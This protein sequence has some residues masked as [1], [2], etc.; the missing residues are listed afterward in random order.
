MK[1]W[2]TA[3]RILLALRKSE[4]RRITLNGML[5]RN[6]EKQEMKIFTTSVVQ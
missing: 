2:K 6:T 4:A 3:E 1:E 5:F